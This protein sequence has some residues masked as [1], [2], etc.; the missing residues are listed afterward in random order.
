MLKLS[1]ND[2]QQ[3]ANNS[4]HE[5]IQINTVNREY[6]GNFRGI[7][8]VRGRS[9]ISIVKVQNN[10]IFQNVSWYFF[11]RHIMIKL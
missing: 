1:M 11:S 10:S 9:V 2:Q 4:I 8:I 5:L 6:G 3:A 7:V